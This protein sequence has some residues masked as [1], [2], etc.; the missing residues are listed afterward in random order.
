M[1]MRIILNISM[2]IH[3]IGLHFI[4]SSLIIANFL[5]IGCTCAGSLIFFHAHS[6]TR[7]TCA[8]KIHTRA[9]LIINNLPHVS[10]FGSH[11]LDYWT[12]ITYSLSFYRMLF[13]PL[14]AKAS[15]YPVS[16]LIVLSRLQACIGQIYFRCLSLRGVACGFPS[17]SPLDKYWLQSRCLSHAKSLK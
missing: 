8:N 11:L 4:K 7:I 3:I 15:G 9:R 13:A 16:Y 10:L 2:I 12:H 17:N 5:K 1:K 14:R 6:G